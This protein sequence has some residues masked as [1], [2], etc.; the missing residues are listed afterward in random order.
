MTEPATSGLKDDGIAHSNCD[1]QAAVTTAAKNEVVAVLSAPYFPSA[2]TSTSQPAVSGNCANSPESTTATPVPTSS[3]EILIATLTLPKKRYK[4]TQFAGRIFVEENTTQFEAPLRTARRIEQQIATL[5]DMRLWVFADSGMNPKA[6]RRKLRK[7]R[8]RIS[9]G[10]A[11]STV[12]RALEP[13]DPL[14]SLNGQLV[15]RAFYLFPIINS[16]LGEGIALAEGIRTMRHQLESF[17]QRMRAA[18]GPEWVLDTPVHA[19]ALTDSATILR[20][21][22]GVM[23][24][25]AVKKYR[26][27]YQAVLERICQE[28]Q[29]LVKVAGASSVALEARWIPSHLDIESERQSVCHVLVDKLARKAVRKKRCFETV[30]GAEEILSVSD[31]IFGQL[32]PSF[33]RATWPK[34]EP[35][36]EK[37]D[38]TDDEE[39]DETFYLEKPVNP[40]WFPAEGS[41]NEVLYDLNSVAGVDSGKGKKQKR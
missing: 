31:C 37:E 33:V 6:A 32:L 21:V 3:G 18:H 11:I 40:K 14:S 28:S 38:E 20:M 25:P 30:F 17:V 9:S 34:S 41:G 8:K 7:D 23:A 29:K 24:V 10:G 39:D 22:A 4:G 35:E 13:D 15:G 19:T 27:L 5:D 12:F 1:N 26:E 2:T 16:N 36:E